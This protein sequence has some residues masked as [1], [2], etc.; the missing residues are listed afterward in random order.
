M[1]TAIKE[2]EL[3]DTLTL[4]LYPDMDQYTPEDVLGEA[5]EFTEQ[6]FFFLPE[7]GF[8]GYKSWSMTERYSAGEFTNELSS[9]AQT[10]F[11]YCDWEATEAAL[12][13]HLERRGYQAKSFALR[14]YSQGEYAEVIVYAKNNP[15][16]YARALGDWF[17]GDIYTLALEEE[18][19][20]IRLSDGD[21]IT[22][23]ETIE[24]IG[25]L[26][27]DTDSD[28]ELITIAKSYF[29][30]MPDLAEVN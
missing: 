16:N 10:V 5:S 18:S 27:L 4:R 2:I 20:Y 15:A 8:Y 21:M 14:G 25:C 12:I 17:R 6:G 22:K 24:S 3:T 1:N 23:S 9:L 30:N 13:K 19:N 28:S 26:L 7:R 29:G 11:E